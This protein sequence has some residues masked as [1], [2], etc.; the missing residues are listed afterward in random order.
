[1]TLRFLVL[2]LALALAACAGPRGAPP[3]PADGPIIYSCADGTQLS[4]T[5]S[6]NEARIAVVGGYTMALPNVGTADAPYYSNGRFGL[7]GRGAQA[8]WQAAQR[9]PVACRGS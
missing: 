3:L 4:V 5:F 6:G 1:M 7:R 9:A 8:T 2:G